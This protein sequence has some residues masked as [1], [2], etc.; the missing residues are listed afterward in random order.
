MNIAA[1]AARA[2]RSCCARGADVPLYPTAP[3]VIGSR[4]RRTA[5]PSRPAFSAGDRIVA[6]N[7]RA[8]P[9]VGR[10]STWPCCRGPTAR[11][12]LAID[13]DGQPLTIR[14]HAGRRVGKFEIGT[15]GVGPVLRPQVARRPP[16]HARG[17]RPACSAATSFSPSTASRGL[18]QPRRSSSASPRAPGRADRL[19]RRARRRSRWTSRSTPEGRDGIERRSASSICTVEVRA[20][21]SDARRRPSSSSAKQNWETTRA[22]RPDARRARSRREHAGEAAHGPGRDRRALGQRRAARLALRSSS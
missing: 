1:R 20:R 14:G 17:S 19:H 12:T 5:R 15:L 10:R 16:R 22:H 11:S 8:D 7:G 18:D 2:R 3:P 13:R 21:R 6:V 9:D 4:R